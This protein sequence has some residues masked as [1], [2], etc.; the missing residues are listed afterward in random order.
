MS[1]NP[2]KRK[3]RPLGKARA[4]RPRTRADAYKRT[5][6]PAYREWHEARREIG[7]KARS[8]ADALFPGLSGIGQS[9]KHSDEAVRAWDKANGNPMT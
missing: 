7:V 5:H 3:T 6:H 4:R 9:M 1:N 2:V 8:E